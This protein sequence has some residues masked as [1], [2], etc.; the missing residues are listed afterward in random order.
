MLKVA[1]V[2]VAG[3]DHNIH[4]SYCTQSHSVHIFKYNNQSCQY[5]IFA[6]EAEAC[7]FIELPLED[8]GSREG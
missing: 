7:R 6:S 3:T 2:H 1:H 8:S 4:I 5:E